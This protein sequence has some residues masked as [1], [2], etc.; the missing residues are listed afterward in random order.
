MNFTNSKTMTNFRSTGQEMFMEVELEL[1]LLFLKRD[2]GLE[3]AYEGLH[4]ALPRLDKPAHCL[5]DHTVEQPLLVLLP[6]LRI[7]TP[8]DHDF[9]S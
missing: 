9:S 7:L 4:L 5:L 6:V 1:G 2:H 8:Q 3:G